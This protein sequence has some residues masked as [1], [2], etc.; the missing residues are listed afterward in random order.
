MRRDH[1]I[2]AV[3]AM[4][5]SM[6]VM[7][8]G[9]ASG[10]DY[11]PVNATAALQQL[12]GWRSRL[13]LGCPISSDAYAALTGALAGDRET[14]YKLARLL[15]RGDGIPR[16]LRGATGWYGK[17]T[18]QGHVAAA[19]EL[20]RPSP[21]GRRYTGRRDK[22]HRG[23]PS[24]GREGRPRCHACPCRHAGLWPRAAARC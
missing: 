18:E 11:G 5:R 22:D 2:A 3:A 14:Q 19:L 17:A 9:A 15:Q 13:D 20:N 23:T 21:R 6:V 4:A 1:R 8:S 16:D 10:E 12:P 24:R 7:R